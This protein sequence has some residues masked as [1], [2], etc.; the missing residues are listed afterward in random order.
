MLLFSEWG[1]Y[2][3]NHV[4]KSSTSNGVKGPQVLDHKVCRCFEH[5]SLC[6]CRWGGFLGL[7]GQWRKHSL[8]TSKLTLVIGH[9][10]GTSW[11]TFIC[12]CLI[13]LHACC[14]CCITI[15][16][17][18]DN[19]KYFPNCRF[20]WTNFPNPKVSCKQFLCNLTGIHF[21][22]PVKCVGSPSHLLYIHP[23][24]VT[25][26]VASY[27]FRHQC[28]LYLLQHQHFSIGSHSR[29]LRNNLNQP[30]YCN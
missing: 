6:C 3:L 19:S 20:S 1:T 28:Q 4:L 10:L 21:E 22:V 14:K 18:S 30:S 29:L 13:T 8:T 26:N 15:L 16:T 23:K 25:F 7:L 27:A 24:E 5:G 9:V 2:L 12:V 17:I 11:T